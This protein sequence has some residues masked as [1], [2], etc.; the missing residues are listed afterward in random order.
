MTTSD[1]QHLITTTETLESLFGPVADASIR[2][3][4]GYIHPRYSEMIAASPFAVIATSGIR[5]LDVSPRGDAPGFIH[6]ED[7][8]TLLLPERR[9]NN[10]IDSLRNLIHDDRI[11]AIF[12]IPGVGEALR[13]NGRAAISIDPAL[14][15]RFAVRNQPPRCVLIITVET[16]FFQCARALKRSKL[17]DPMSWGPPGSVPSAGRILDELTEGSIDGDNYDQALPQR[18]EDTL[19]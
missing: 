4:I 15:A 9:G 8:K 5:G 18:Q 14:L 7:E 13:V 17:W 3:E 6:V 10:R 12:L 19:Y 1:S 11:S 16:A 2:K